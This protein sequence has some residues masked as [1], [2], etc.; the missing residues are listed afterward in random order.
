MV[1]GL[2][3]GL[4]VCAFCSSDCFSAWGDILVSFGILRHDV[5]SIARTDALVSAS[6][7]LL[8]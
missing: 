8:L 3:L 1:E 2:S 7:I 5:G 4:K 6:N